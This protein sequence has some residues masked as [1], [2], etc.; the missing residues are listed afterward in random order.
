[1]S[2][3]YMELKICMQISFNWRGNDMDC[4]TSGLGLAGDMI[5]R[6]RDQVTIYQP[7]KEQTSS[8]L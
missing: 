7:Y 5:F 8:D 1:M 3:I 2:G 4:L 6:Q